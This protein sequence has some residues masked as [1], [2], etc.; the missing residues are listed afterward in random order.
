MLDELSACQ[1]YEN[2]NLFQAGNDFIALSQS[3]CNHH[4]Y[5]IWP[6]GMALIG[7]SNDFP[8]TTSEGLEKPEEENW[9]VENVCVVELPAGETWYV[10]SHDKPKPVFHEWYVSQRSLEAA[11]SAAGA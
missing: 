5:Q 10:A 7:C 4:A 6:Y 9:L 3:V 1:V 11:A 2:K 8:T